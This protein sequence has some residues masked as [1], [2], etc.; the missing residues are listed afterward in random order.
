MKLISFQ[1]L[2]LLPLLMAIACSDKGTLPANWVAN[3]P[4]TYEATHGKLREVVIFKSDGTYTHSCWVAGKEIVGESGKWKIVEKS[5]EI[6]LTPNEHFSVMYDP[7]S[8]TVLSA[9]E[10]TSG[11]T[12]W[13]IPDGPTV[14]RI[15]FA[16]SSDMILKKQ[17]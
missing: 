15:T 7:Q 4:G 9:P 11:R 8:N 12:Y 2:I 3:F 17:K 6:N 13:P 5:A 1:Y 10:Q 14:E 16:I